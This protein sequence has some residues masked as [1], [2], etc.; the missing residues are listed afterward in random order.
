MV[1]YLLVSKN[2][3]FSPRCAGACGHVASLP[4]KLHWRCLTSSLTSCCQPSS[5]SSRCEPA[6]CSRIFSDGHPEA[7]PGVWT[8]LLLGARQPLTLNLLVM[9]AEKATHPGVLLCGNNSRRVFYTLPRGSRQHGATNLRE[10]PFTSP[11]LL[12]PP[13]TVSA[14][15]P[16]S[17]LL[18]GITSQINYLHP[19]PYLRA[20]CWRNSEHTHL[21]CLCVC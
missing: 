15:C 3:S 14:I 21:H 17:I 1:S 5:S 20:S 2:K 13:P 8:Q 7:Q 19:G 9:G 18:P 4:A 12:T 10:L 11:T 6:F 16:S